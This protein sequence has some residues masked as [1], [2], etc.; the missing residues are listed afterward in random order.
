M[1]K[2]TPKKFYEIDPLE[3]EMKFGRSVLYQFRE[4]LLPAEPHEFEYL[5]F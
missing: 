4:C 2:F 1:S 5:S 3:Y